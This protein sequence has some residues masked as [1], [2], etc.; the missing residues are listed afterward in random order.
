MLE[1]NHTRRLCALTL[2]LTTAV[3]TLSRVTNQN[4]KQCCIIS[5]SDKCTKSP[6]NVQYTIQG[7]RYLTT[8]LLPVLLEYQISIHFALWP[9]VFELQA[10]LQQVTGMTPKV[11]W[12]P[13][14]Q[15]YSICVTSITKSYISLRFRYIAKHFRVKAILKNKCTVWHNLLPVCPPNDPKLTL[16]TKRSKIS[17]KDIASTSE[18]QISLHL[19]L[20]PAIF[21]LQTNLRQVHRMKTKSV[22]GVRVWNFLRIGLKRCLRRYQCC[23]FY[24]I[25]KIIF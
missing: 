15:R 18:F 9:G 23:F 6:Q 24:K 2:C 5:I 16:N 13:Q 4:S 20:W 25:G 10:T 21:K 17:P 1:V 12:T 14:E 19:A 11:P 22:G 8:Y 3:G 7:R